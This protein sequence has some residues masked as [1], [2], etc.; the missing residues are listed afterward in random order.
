M[1][2][3][4]FQIGNTVI[5]ATSLVLSI[6][7]LLSNKCYKIS[8][9]IIRPIYWFFWIIIILGITTELG[10]SIYKNIMESNEE[11][12]DPIKEFSMNMYGIVIGV[13]V[14]ILIYFNDI[15][16]RI[17]NDI[18]SNSIT[19]K[20]SGMFIVGYFMF[21]SVIINIITMINI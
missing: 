2:V 1:L 6:S 12:I 16:Y 19:L 4:N 5:V 3:K 8:N 10:I 11:D 17:N 21:L 15:Y 7:L 14:A 9:F 13:V 20:S 18:P